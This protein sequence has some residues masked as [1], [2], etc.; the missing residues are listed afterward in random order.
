MAKNVKITIS[1]VD[2]TKKALSSTQRGL[3][4]LKNSVFSLKGALLG[5]GAGA[6]LVSIAKISARFEDLR[7][8]LSSVTG[9][10]ENGRK[11]F[12]KRLCY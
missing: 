12:Y 2:K 6:L 1:A 5:L 3:S 8:S 10:I 4:K 7:D 11:A 9:S